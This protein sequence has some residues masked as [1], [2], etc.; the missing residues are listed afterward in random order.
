[1][2]AGVSIAML[3][4]VLWWYRR[5]R[6]RTGGVLA[7][8]AWGS[9]RAGTPARAPAA[10]GTSRCARTRPTIVAELRRRPVFLSLVIV[11]AVALVVAPAFVPLSPARWLILLLGLGVAAP[12]AWRH[13]AG[14]RPRP[15]PGAAGD[16]DP[17]LEL[18][19]GRLGLRRRVGGRSGAGLA[20]VGPVVAVAAVTV[21]LLLGGHV[22]TPPRHRAAAAP[23]PKTTGPTT[24]TTAPPTTVP[25]APS[26]STP[27]AAPTVT[28]TPATPSPT[29][30][31]APPP[32]VDPLSALLQ[33][34][35]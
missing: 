29:P 21:V 16:D 8:P 1:V 18:D 14:S 26:A 15:H 9:T 24:S 10:P 31:P 25:A 23:A 4:A 11:S 2:L 22:R 35:R 13:Q 33:V 19:V 20:A 32:A 7:D 6:S 3:A 28:F 5:R 27:G 12:V 30:P 17:T 34:L